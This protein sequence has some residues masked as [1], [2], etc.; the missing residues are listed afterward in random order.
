[1]A[2][3]N[4]DLLKVEKIADE[5]AKEAVNN[6]SVCDLLE[7]QIKQEKEIREAD[8]ITLKGDVKDMK[9][10]DKE[11]FKK[12]DGFGKL[13]ITTLITAVFTLLTMLSTIALAYVNYI[14]K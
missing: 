11:I 13:M 5:A 6:C 9:E 8:I 7:L 4:G 2:L 12:I 1:M 14:K 10:T 3:E